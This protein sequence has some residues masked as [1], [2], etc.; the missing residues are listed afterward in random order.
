M[1]NEERIE[2]AHSL[3]KDVFG[4][5]NPEDF[6]SYEIFMNEV[7][8]VGLSE[9]TESHLREYLSGWIGGHLRAYELFA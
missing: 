9:N 7:S 3:I 1:S 5:D 8:R 6:G 4:Y 2:I